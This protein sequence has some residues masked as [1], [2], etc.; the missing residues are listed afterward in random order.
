[1]IQ[2]RRHLAEG[3]VRSSL[4]RPGATSWEHPRQSEA[5]EARSETDEGPR[6]RGCRGLCVDDQDDRQVAVA[7]SALLQDALRLGNVEDH[8]HAGEDNGEGTEKGTENQ[9]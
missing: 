8:L 3:M 9:I 5:S 7:G 4:I 6:R 1:M 2:P